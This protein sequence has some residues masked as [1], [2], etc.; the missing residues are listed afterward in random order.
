MRY[1]LNYNYNKLFK[2][3]AVSLLWPRNIETSVLCLMLRIGADSVDWRFQVEGAE[4]I[5]Y[6]WNRLRT[7]YASINSVGKLM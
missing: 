7:Q 5:L 3:L 6:L 1:I 4:L 2:C